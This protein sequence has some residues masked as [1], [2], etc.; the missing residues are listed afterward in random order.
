MLPLSDITLE[1]FIANHAKKL[2]TRRGPGHFFEKLF[3]H[4]DKNFTPINERLCLCVIRIKGRFFNY[5]LRRGGQG[6]IL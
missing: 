6:S 3:T 1:K 5:S 2:T 4:M